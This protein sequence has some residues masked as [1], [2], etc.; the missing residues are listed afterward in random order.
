MENHIIGA[1]EGLGIGDKLLKKFAQGLT[2]SCQQE[3]QI[4]H[5]DLGAALSTVSSSFL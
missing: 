3:A 1:L 5:Y 4:T 2:T